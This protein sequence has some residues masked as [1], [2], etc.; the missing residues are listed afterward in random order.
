MISA[1][2]AA[3]MT[4]DHCVT[5][6]GLLVDRRAR[7]RARARHALEEAA[8]EVR[9]RLRD[10][11]CWF[12]SSFWP[13]PRGDRLGHRDRLEQAEQRDRE[14][15]AREARGSAPASSVGQREATGSAAGISP[16]TCTPRCVEAEPRR[17]RAAITITTSSSSGSSAPAEP[18]LEPAQREH[19][20]DRRRGRRQRSPR[21]S[22]PPSRQREPEAHE[23]VVV[24][25]AQRRAG[26]AGS[27]AG[28]ARAARRRRAVKPTITECEM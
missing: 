21:G 6:A 24:G 18:A 7:Q 10:R 8:G 4:P 26:R 1:T 13:R 23:E 3:E 5:R 27:S 9:E 14:R 15:A 28:R 25:V 2:A 20:R 11:H 17:R 22:P 19:E 16:T 12:M